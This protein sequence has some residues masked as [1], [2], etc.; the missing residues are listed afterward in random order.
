MQCLAAE[1]IVISNLL[2]P[3][4]VDGVVLNPEHS[5]MLLPDH[6]CLTM[7][8]AFSSL[9]MY[10]QGIAALHLLLSVCCLLNREEWQQG[11]IAPISIHTS[12]L[13]IF[14]SVSSHGYLNLDLRDR[15]SKVVVVVTHI[16]Y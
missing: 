11:V 7:V 6:E 4:R 9:L 13:S 8:V 12:Y 10:Q 3:K 5:G 16:I 15:N 1:V 14:T 2:C